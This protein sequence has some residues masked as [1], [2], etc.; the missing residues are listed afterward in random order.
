MIKNRGWKLLGMMCVCSA[1]LF[2]NP[3]K[4]EAAEAEEGAVVK[5]E[6]EQV[7][8]YSEMSAESA[9]VEQ[10]SQGDT[11]E[12]VEDNGDGWV[13]VFSESGEEGYLMADGKS[14][15]VEAEAGDVRQDV[16]DYALTFLGNPYVYGG[17]SL[18]NG[19]D[20]SG[21]TQSVFANFG[22]SLSRTAADQSY[23]GT[24]VDLGSIQPG[25]LLFYSDG[26]GISHVAI[27]MGGGQIVHAA[28]AASGITTSNYDYSTPVSASR[29]W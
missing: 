21:F 19:A 20:C 26:G 7:S 27:Y 12:V 16:V 11:Y 4:A 22:I 3:A 1:V 10:V 6:A 25:D 15:V 5:V 29:Y 18:T 23:G 14:A 13:K 24:A 8:L 2:A 28:N 9:V 17:T